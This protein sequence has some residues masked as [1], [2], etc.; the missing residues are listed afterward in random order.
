MAA[1]IALEERGLA[2]GRSAAAV[3]KMTDA[4]LRSLHVTEATIQAYR[5][6]TASLNTGTAATAAHTKATR[7][8]TAAQ[9]ELHG[10]M[11]GTA[12]AAGALWLTYGSMVPLLAAFATVGA[13][14]KSFKMGSEFDTEMRFIQGLTRQ[15]TERMKGLND[16]ILELA[17]TTIYTPTQIVQGLRILSQAGFTIEQ[18]MAAVNDVMRLARI[19]EMEVSEAANVAQT[20]MYAFGKT[21]NDVGHI[22]NNLA[23]AATMSATNVKE[24]AAALTTGSEVGSLYGVTLEETTAALTVLAQRHIVGQAAGTAF[25]NMMR[26]IGGVTE[27][28]KAMVKGLGIE[29]HDATGE[30][31]PMVTVLQDIKRAMDEFSPDV[32]QAM[33]RQWMT[34]RGIRAFV[35]MIEQADSFLVESYMM[36]LQA[37][38]GMPVSELIEKQLTEAFSGE[39]LRA[40]SKFETTLIEAFQRMEAGAVSLI[41]KFGEL[42]RT[43]DA[44][45]FINTVVEGSVKFGTFLVDNFK[46]IVQLTKAYVAY[47]VAVL[48]ASMA[49]STFAAT[50]SIKWLAALS[51][52]IRVF[53]FLVAG[54]TA[55]YALFRKELGFE[56]TLG[57]IF[58]R[59]IL[60]I[61]LLKADIEDLMDKADPERIVRDKKEQPKSLLFGWLFSTEASKRE[62]EIARGAM[63]V[64]REQLSPKPDPESDDFLSRRAA[65]RKALEEEMGIGS[66]KE[67]LPALRNLEVENAEHMIGIYRRQAQVLEDIRGMSKE[68]VRAHMDKLQAESRALALVQEQEARVTS[69]RELRDGAQ[70]SITSHY[71]KVLGYERKLQESEPS[72]ERAEKITALEKD[73][74]RSLGTIVGHYDKMVEREIALQAEVEKGGKLGEDFKNALTEAEKA[75]ISMENV[76]S[77]EGLIEGWEKYTREVAKANAALTD[78]ERTSGRTFPVMQENV[79]NLGKQLQE[80]FKQL[81]DPNTKL[82]KM[83]VESYMSA[84][85][86]ADPKFYDNE[87][88]KI[89]QR[90]L[91]AKKTFGASADEVERLAGLLKN[92]L[93]RAQEEATGVKYMN[94]LDDQYN[95]IGLVGEALHAYNDRLMLTNKA[96]T[97]QIENKEVWIE[98]T[99]EKMALHR[100]MNRELD[101][102]NKL[103]QQELSL[104]Q[105]KRTLGLEVATAGMGTARASQ[106]KTEMGI[107]Q[108]GESTALGFEQK[109][110]FDEA[111]DA[112]QLAEEEIE[113]SR[114]SYETRLQLQEDWRAGMSRAY[115]DMLADTAN[116]YQQSNDLATASFSGISNIFAELLFNPFEFNLKKMLF[117][118][119]ETMRRMLSEMLAQQL[120]AM[121][122]EKIF[123]KTAAT[124]KTTALALEAQAMSVMAGLSAFASTAAIPQVGPAL[125]PAAAAAAVAATQPMAATITALS[126][127]AAASYEGGGYTG[128]GARTGGVDGRG[129]FP[130]ILHPNETIIDHN[131]E[132]RQ[133]QTAPAVNVPIRIVN[134]VDPKIVESWANSASGERVIMNIVSRNQAMMR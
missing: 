50:S 12:G 15:T 132:P 11:R 92:N 130:A 111:A 45:G 52:H 47:R 24:M 36:M 25:K 121:L 89:E 63:N 129:G 83:S 29:T 102:S 37:S 128:K 125:A 23:Q 86:F 120:M 61:R 19:G 103:A 80:V 5:A 117:S 71:D 104:Q 46:Q 62:L 93:K 123:M 26:D 59:A 9:M 107:R 54:A 41:Q 43:D 56:L 69:L 119:V 64:W 87:L 72:P 42:W 97:L 81:S 108:R 100:E 95:A 75:L 70:E 101:R 14:L 28:A 34:R 65:R 53:S 79:K 113:M 7:G 131:R 77:I 106:L 114:Y 57:D 116:Y 76:G 6:K 78:T 112:R 55:A 118:F 20:A 48:A 82:H 126:A 44:R 109:K 17:R 96:E 85:G 91:I 94:D 16:S 1:R 124:A 8:L 21:A 30:M 51:P 2:A 60:E 67:P 31:R 74:E 99:L 88:K 68:D 122:M 73:R 90:V 110:E 49:N 18:S 22:V 134:V 127:A 66:A 4:D 133:Q 13:T 58:K 3:A 35:P 39:R 38:E 10:A 33:M 105:Q 115:E 40:V 98:K 27:E 32:R 84:V